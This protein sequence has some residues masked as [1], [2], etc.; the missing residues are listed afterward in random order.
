MK[1]R[2]AAFIGTDLC[3][4]L[5]FDVVDITSSYRINS[6]LVCKSETS[7]KC[8]ENIQGQVQGCATVDMF[9][10]HAHIFTWSVCSRCLRYLFDAQH[11][12]RGV[13]IQ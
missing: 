9:D 13:S 2:I 7:A 12:F 1:D 10:S 5:S 11:D 4:L 6:C 3:F 8:L